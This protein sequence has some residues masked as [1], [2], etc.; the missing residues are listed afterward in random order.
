VIRQLPVVL[1][2]VVWGCLAFGQQ[3]SA[4]TS[5][6]G[7]DAQPPIHYAGPGVTAPQVVAPALSSAFHRCGSVTLAAIVDAN[8]KAGEI[9]V[10]RADDANMAKLASKL[11][12]KTKFNPG[13]YNGVPAAVAIT[14]VLDNQICM[15]HL[16]NESTS[17]AVSLRESPQSN[18][19]PQGGSNSPAGS[20]SAE[21][22]GT[23]KVGGNI[24]AP[25]AIRSVPL[26]FSS[27][28]RK[29]KIS[30]SC[31]IGL[32]VDINGNPQDVHVIQGLEPSLDRNAIEAVKGYLFRPAMKDDSVPVPVEVTVKVDFRLK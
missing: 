18:A 19:I 1:A 30:G 5:S 9:D 26:M 29:K 31:L 6:A 22:P 10:I 8:G 21:S 24:S 16:L 3:D 11:L 27:Y 14:A 20:G 7:T 4:L 32:I 15:R 23:Y 28:A 13:T 2:A 17:I 25:I 12:A